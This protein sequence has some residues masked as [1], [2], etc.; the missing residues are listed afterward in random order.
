MK[1]LKIELVGVQVAEQGGRRTGTN[2]QQGLALDQAVVGL[3]S[4][5][6]DQRLLGRVGNKVNGNEIVQN[7]NVGIQKNNN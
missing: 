2:V 1:A 5:L 3:Q 4:L 6:A 7:D